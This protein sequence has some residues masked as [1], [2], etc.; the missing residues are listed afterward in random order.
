M[1]NSI[2]FLKFKN[3]TFSNKYT[4]WYVNIISFRIKNPLNEN[5]YGENHHI[6]PKCIFPEHKN[7]NVN[8]IKLT[9]REHFLVH[10]LLSKMFVS[11]KHTKQMQNAINSFRKTKTN[12]RI[13]SGWQYDLMKKFAKQW[14]LNKKLTQEHKNKISL[15]IK[16]NKMSQEQKDKIGNRVRNSIIVSN[17]KLNK[18]KYIQKNDLDLYLQNNWYIGRLPNWKKGKNNPNYGKKFSEERKRKISQSN[19]GKKRSKETCE[20]IRQS[21]IKKVA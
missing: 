4:K 14:C 18:T 6:L 12:Q 15:K 5:I 17:I 1:I 19:L 3:L 2:L 9:F 10:W 21:K 16:G 11:K 8:I 13:F 20:N 7:D